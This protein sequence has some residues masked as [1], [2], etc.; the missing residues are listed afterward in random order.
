MAKT[1]SAKTVIKTQQ[2]SIRRSPKF[3]PFLITGGVIGVILGAGLG[4]SIP[5]DQR[6]AEPV[7]TYLIA[8]GAGIGVVAGIVAALIV[9]RIGVARA[10]TLEATKL[11]Q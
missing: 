3:L 2:V 9:D 6:T 10:K 11:E 4:L 8:Y 5:A 1:P 7:I